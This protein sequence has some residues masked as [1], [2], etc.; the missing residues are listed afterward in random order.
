MSI[1]HIGYFLS[2]MVLLCK[3]PWQQ[4]QTYVSQLPK[5]AD[6]MYAT[7]WLKVLITDI[8]TKIK[9][10]ISYLF[11]KLKYK[12]DVNTMCDLL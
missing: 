6:C 9:K 11:Y 1:H 12:D 10:Y 3:T 5:S 7:H 8:L 2:D 4:L